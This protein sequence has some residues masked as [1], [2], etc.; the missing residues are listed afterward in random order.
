VQWRRV[1]DLLDRRC[2]GRHV[3][4][5]YTFRGFFIQLTRAVQ[6]LCSIQAFRRSCKLQ[7]ST[8]LLMCWYS[9]ATVLDI[10]PRFQT[11]KIS[12]SPAGAQRRPQNL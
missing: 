3:A 2:P 7:S 1:N 12:Y 6:D 11:I 9:R 5:L 4:Q 8:L 10:A